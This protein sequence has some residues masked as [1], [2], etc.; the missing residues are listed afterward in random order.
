MRDSDERDNELQALVESESVVLSVV[1]EWRNS[2]SILSFMSAFL[3]GPA[4][5]KDR[6]QLVAVSLRL[7]PR[8]FLD[9][10]RIAPMKPVVDRWAG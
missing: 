7:W 8:V 4:N 2:C 9:V 3:S 6:A 5:R 10:T 1:R